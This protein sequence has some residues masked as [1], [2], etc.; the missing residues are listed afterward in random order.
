MKVATNSENL[1]ILR[2]CG[3]GIAAR[4]LLLQLVCSHSHLC[5][6]S[7]MLLNRN[8]ESAEVISSETLQ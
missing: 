6:A 2:L 1:G 7:Q 3:H 8:G 4:W 5:S